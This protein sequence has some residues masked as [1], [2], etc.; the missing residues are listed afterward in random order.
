MNSESLA[1]S[2]ARLYRMTG[3]ENR[4]T[5]FTMSAPEI[6]VEA[7]LAIAARRFGL[8]RV[9]RRAVEQEVSMWALTRRLRWRGF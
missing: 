9:V 2:V 4:F 7:E 3:Q 5:A 1:R 6:L 8:W